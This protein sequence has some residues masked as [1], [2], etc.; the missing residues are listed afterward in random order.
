MRIVRILFYKDSRY[1]SNSIILFRD[2]KLIID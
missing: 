1:I 2:Y